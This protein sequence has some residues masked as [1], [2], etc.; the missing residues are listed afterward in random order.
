MKSFK[1]FLMEAKET[2]LV[3]EPETKTFS[4]KTLKRG[5]ILKDGEGNLWEID[6]IQDSI[7]S[8][9]ILKK[10][11]KDSWS[12]DQIHKNYGHVRKDANTDPNFSGQYKKLYHTGKWR[13]P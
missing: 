4:G 13:L 11:P 12:W 7:L 6:R 9:V 10:M 3:W 8:L 2:P 5:D 1:E